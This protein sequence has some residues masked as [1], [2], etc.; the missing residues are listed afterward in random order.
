MTSS[1]PY[2]QHTKADTTPKFSEYAIKNSK[3]PTYKEKVIGNKTTGVGVL[4]SLIDNSD[5]TYYTTGPFSKG[6]VSSLN[7]TDPLSAFVANSTLNQFK[8]IFI[9]SSKTAN[10]NYG[11]Q[12]VY[13]IINLLD[14]VGQKG[15]LTFNTLTIFVNNSY[16]QDIGSSNQYNKNAVDIS[17]RIFKVDDYQQAANATGSSPISGLVKITVDGQ[18]FYDIKFNEDITI[19]PFDE[20]GD[21]VYYYLGIQISSIPTQ[22]A[23]SQLVFLRSVQGNGTIQPTPNYNNNTFYTEQNLLMKKIP[24]GTNRTVPGT[25]YFTLSKK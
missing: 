14:G 23:Q 8:D 20:N 19:T 6:Y 5:K 16:L 17:A 1:I 12:G 24:G 25:L 15:S 22:D 13:Q 11:G 9:S 4:T 3:N 7:Y 10:S 21:P 2:S 18:G